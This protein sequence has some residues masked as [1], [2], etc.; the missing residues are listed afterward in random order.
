MPVQSGEGEPSIEDLKLQ[1]RAKEEEAV[2][3][4]IEIRNS[5][6]TVQSHLRQRSEDGHRIQEMVIQAEK[7]SHA[8]CQDVLKLRDEALRRK[9]DNI[10]Y[11]K[12]TSDERKQ[13]DL[14]VAQAANKSLA[15]AF[16]RFST[17]YSHKAAQFVM[18]TL[19][20][21]NIV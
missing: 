13:T 17:H 7:E 14:L 1:L 4:T 5:I 21:L 8:F 6:Q 19:K 15:G 12:R 2:K 20:Y 11:E 3:L 18:R 10:E 16:Y 9:D